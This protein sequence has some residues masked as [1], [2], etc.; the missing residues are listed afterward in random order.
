MSNETPHE[1]AN[2]TNRSFHHEIT[3]VAS[4]DAI[5]RRWTDVA[6]WSEWDGGL[7]DAALDD[8][9]AVG[10]TG[11]IEPLSG[12]STDFTV[13]AVVPGERYEFET[14]L[15]GARLRVDRRITGANPT[16]FRHD[17]S[18]VGGLAWLWSRLLGRGFRRE[19]PPTM[20][21]LRELAESDG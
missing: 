13:T 4:P 11:T 17:V 19:L 16:R 14:R 20:E 3:T 12:R 15:P 10:A 18:F 1:P 21:R 7:R 5:V 2:G 6:G 8:G 9:F